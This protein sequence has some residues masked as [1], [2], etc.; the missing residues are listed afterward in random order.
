MKPGKKNLE[1]QDERIADLNRGL[2]RDQADKIK[3]GGLPPIRG[4]RGPNQ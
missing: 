1:K 4:G 2:D 3:G